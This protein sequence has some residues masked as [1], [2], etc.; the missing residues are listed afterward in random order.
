MK[1]HI[2]GNAGSGKTTLASRLGEA[3]D[4]PVYSLDSVVWKERWVA[5]SKEERTQGENELIGHDHWVI[6]GVSR[7]V[8]DNSDYVVF[9]DV[10]RTVCL[11]R[12][13]KRNLPYLFRSRPELPANCP[14]III[15]PRLLKLI[16]NF[17]S[18]GKPAILS[19]LNQKRGLVIKGSSNIDG[20]VAQ[21][22][23]DLNK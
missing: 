10:P 18:L 7:L 11:F 19:S 21:I 15:L 22:L 23:R 16:W 8:R 20:L 1:I 2:T 17:P 14:E 3:L 4:L 5:A 12:C 9:L 6:E 13:L